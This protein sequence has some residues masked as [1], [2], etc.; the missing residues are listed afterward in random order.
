MDTEPRAWTKTIVV[1]LAA[2]IYYVLPAAAEPFTGGGAVF[3][4]ASGARPLA[5]GGA[6]VGL[7]D[8]GNALFL[9]PAGLGWADGISILSSLDRRL[10]MASLGTIGACF[11]RFGLGVHLLDLGTLTLTDQTGH[12]VG[13]FTYRNIGLIGAIGLRVSDIPFFKNVA[14]ADTM[15]M[16][17]RLRLL[18]IDTQDP[19]DA[20]ALAFDLPILFR[21]EQVSF[22]KGILTGFGAGLVLENLI[23]PSIRYTNGHEEQ[24]ESTLTMGLAMEFVDRV[25]AAIDFTSERCLRLGVEWRPVLPLAVRIGLRYEGTWIP[26]LGVGVQFGAYALDL[27]YVSH[28]LLTNELRGSF[29][30]K[31]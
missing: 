5:M 2:V 8:D 14:F 28:P 11:S 31:W 18:Q 16:G 26:S 7:A 4:L 23:V 3:D 20:T 12:P 24:W 25:T 6:F 19:G 21:N 22:G 13:E 30:V 17:L 9:N 29:T 1:G 27:T 10:G 15:A